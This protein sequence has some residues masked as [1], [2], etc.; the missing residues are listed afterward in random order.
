MQ[1]PHLYCIVLAYASAS[2]AASH[3]EEQLMRK[4]KNLG[5]TYTACAACRPAQAL[6]L[7]SHELAEDASSGNAAGPLAIAVS[8]FMTTVMNEGQ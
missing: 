1:F 8:G 5:V 3:N 7:A 6:C 4:K 2:Q